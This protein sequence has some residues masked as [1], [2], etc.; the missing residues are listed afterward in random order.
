M[1][2]T[3]AL[4]G[5][6]AGGG[7]YLGN[8]AYVAAISPTSCP[9]GCV[10]NGTLSVSSY[11]AMQHWEKEIATANASATAGAY[12]SVVLLDPFT[13]S[14]G[15]TVSQSR[16]VDEL[17]GASLALTAV[18]AAVARQR[19]GV[20][21][22]LLLANE[23][24][25]AEE[26]ESEAVSQIENLEGPDHIVAVAG[27]GLSTANTE[28]AATALSQVSMPMFG[29][30]TTGDQ[31]NSLDYQGFFQIAPDVA[32]QVHTL[33]SRLGLTAPQPVTLISSDQKTDIYSSDLQS[34]FT[35]AL[36]Y[37]PP[38]GEFSYDPA[39]PEPQFASDAQN[40]CTSQRSKHPGK[41]PSTS[42]IVLYAGREATLPVLVGQFQQA[43][44]CAG[45]TVT[46][47]TGSDSNAL[48]ASVTHES[49]PPGAN[50]TVVYSDIESVASLSNAFVTTTGPLPPKPASSATSCLNQKY[51][52]W[53]V[54]TYNSVMAAVSTVSQAA[55]AADSRTASPTA[56]PSGPLTAAEVQSEAVDM[57]GSVP[58]R[59]PN[60]SFGFGTNGELQSPA[61]PVYTDENGTCS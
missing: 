1:P 9:A 17:Q 8:R 31:F 42:L 53:E 4:A 57:M 23:G 46:I 30:V 44:I 26:G 58:Y 21:I 28:T 45:L 29:A 35:T 13:Y 43:S 47:V 2:L 7:L 54:A 38:L 15:G 41:A 48:P 55:S 20:A 5:A 39:T 59:A 25:S 32:A 10:T 61:I 37:R 50:V 40:I 60:G 36:G 56:S 14:T 18:N 34:D 52:P 27:M 19:T 33:V 6:L 51:D 16:V 11:P 24:T 22:Q 3:I 49:D 12:Y